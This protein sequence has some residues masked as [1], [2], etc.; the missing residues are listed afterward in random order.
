M[1]K[2]I[3]ILYYYFKTKYFMRFADRAALL[4]WQNSRVTGFLRKYI[5]KSGYYSR[6]FRNM[7]VRNWQSFPTIDKKEMMEN[8]DELN[9]VG[10]SQKEAFEL[11]LN[12][13]KTR[14]FKPEINNITVGL[15]S[16]TSGNRGLF[17]VSRMERYRWVGIILA[18][19]LPD[20]IFK[21]HRIAFFLR[22]NSNLYTGVKSRNISFEFFDLLDSTDHNLKKLDEYKPSIIV[23]PPSMLKIIAANLNRISINPVKIISV[24]EVLEELDRRYLEKA[25]NQ[26]VHQIYQ[27]TEG[28]LACTCRYG[29]LHINEDVLAVQREYVDKDKFIPV[30]TDF[31]RTSQPVI[32][33]RLN[34]IL[35]ESH[36]PCPCGSMCLRIAGIEGRCDD[37]FYLDSVDG[38]SSV[39]VFPDFLSRAVIYASDRIEE[40]KVIQ[41]TR[42]EILVYVDKTEEFIPVKESLIKL[43]TVKKCQIPEIIQLKSLEIDRTKKFRRIESRIHDR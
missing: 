1:L 21:K 14:N 41:N 27:A 4:K 23:S 8:F 29:N 40:Y 11:A 38:S 12:S 17:L 5:A 37:I 15:S 3:I 16:G 33:Y 28:F 30:I 2:T 32:R 22:A 6:K 7:D 10:I 18:K 43:F 34:D 9:T 31:S 42:R 26:T 13:E 20:S 35:T 19:N 25:F 39:A 36:E 24:A